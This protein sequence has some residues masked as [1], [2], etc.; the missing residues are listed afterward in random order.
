MFKRNRIV[1][2][3]VKHDV[4]NG[5]GHS[6]WHLLGALDPV[7]DVGVINWRACRAF[8][9]VSQQAVLVISQH[10][11]ALCWPIVQGV[12]EGLI[13]NIVG[14]VGLEHKFFA[15]GARCVTVLIYTIVKHLLYYIRLAL[16]DFHLF[17]VVYCTSLDFRRC[18]LGVVWKTAIMRPTRMDVHYSSFVL[19]PAIFRPKRQR[20]INFWVPD[21]LLDVLGYFTLIIGGVARVISRVTNFHLSSVFVTK[22]VFGVC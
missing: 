2:T 6:N 3:D 8:H 18:N 10:L 5:V 17:L 20:R 22:L 1:I 7:I 16:V 21:L 9:L 14:V 11:V 19:I 15:I 13:A 4:R 12:F